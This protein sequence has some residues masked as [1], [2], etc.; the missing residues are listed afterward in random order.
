M[1]TPSFW[2]R[3][4]L[5]HSWQSQILAPVSSL[6][7]WGTRLSQSCNA[8]DRDC[9]L[10]VFCV[11]NLVAGGSGKTP[12][13]LALA[14]ILTKAG[15]ASAPAFVTRGYKSG[16]SSAVAVSA[17]FESSRWGDEAL[18]LARAHPTIVS[19][20]RYDGA[21]TARRNGADAIILDDGLLSSGLLKTVR[22]CVIDSAMGFGNGATIP[23]GPLRVPLER[24]FASVDAFIVLGHDFDIS[25]KLRNLL[26][27]TIPVFSARRDVDVVRPL[28]GSASSDAAAAASY[29]G[30]CGLGYP[31]KFRQTLAASG[32]SLTDFVSFADHHPYTGADLAALGERAR[33]SSSRLITTEKDAVRLPPD[34]P[35]RSLIDVLPITVTLENEDGLIRLLRGYCP[36]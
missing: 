25:P 15:L 24:G 16:I 10:P 29:I 17:P 21:M 8:V 7:Q 28:D 30:F 20:D 11:G 27:Q 22:F 35:E 6:Y 13:A 19:P 33:A 12:V 18:L 2:Y 31:N 9:G 32:F 34:C 3:A 26:P 14:R 1:K 4:D 23:S 5:G 36:S